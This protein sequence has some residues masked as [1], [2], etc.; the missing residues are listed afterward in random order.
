MIACINAE[1]C[2]QPGVRS[3]NTALFL[4]NDFII[5]NALYVSPW[6]TK[7]GEG[8]GILGSAPVSAAMLCCEYAPRRAETLQ[9]STDINPEVLLTVSLPNLHQTPV[10]A[11]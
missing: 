6:S 2:Q 9:T 10:D 7:L 3:P 4:L 11:T 8:C 5:Y 1:Q